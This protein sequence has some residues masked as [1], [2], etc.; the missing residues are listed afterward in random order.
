MVGCRKRGK[1]SGPVDAG[2]ERGDDPFLKLQILAEEGNFGGE[3]GDLLVFAFDDSLIA[4]NVLD[5]TLFTI[6]IVLH[7]KVF[8]FRRAGRYHRSAWRGRWA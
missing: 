7:T 5:A 8:G 3:I 2:K 6:F 1:G 4:W